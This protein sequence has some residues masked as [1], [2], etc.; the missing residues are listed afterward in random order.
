MVRCLSE[1]DIDQTIRTVT[2]I[3]EHIHGQADQATILE[4]DD[5][6]DRHHHDPAD[7]DPDHLVVIVIAD[8]DHTPDPRVT[9]LALTEHSNFLLFLLLGQSL[10]R[11]FSG[12]RQLQQT[13][14]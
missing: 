2:L 6:P 7:P 10:A 11:R 5:G 8:A 13:V 12:I 1:E 3:P 9:A 14:F 4:N